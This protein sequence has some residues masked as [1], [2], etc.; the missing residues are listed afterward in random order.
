MAYSTKTKEEAFGLFAQGLSFDDILKEMKRKRRKD[1]KLTKKTLIDWARKYNWEQRRAAIRQQAETAADK[2]R[3][4]SYS[5]VLTDMTLLEAQIKIAL[6]SRVPTS[7]EG[8]VNALIKVRKYVDS[9]R[10]SRNT[11]IKQAGNNLDVIVGVIWKVLL[12]DEEVGRLLRDREEYIL[13]RID[14]ELEKEL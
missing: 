5:E 14:E 9:L 13:E 6:K 12:D 7:F 2:K 4:S 11:H 1:F 10:G 3:V 8:G